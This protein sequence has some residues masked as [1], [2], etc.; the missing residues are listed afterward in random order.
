MSCLA[1]WRAASYK[2]QTKYIIPGM[3]NFIIKADTVYKLEKVSN[4]RHRY[5]I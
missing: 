1:S 4:Y 5:Y 3:S 2:M